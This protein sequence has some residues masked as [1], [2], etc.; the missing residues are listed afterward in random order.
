MSFAQ[1]PIIAVNVTAKDEGSGKKLDGAI[2]K[3]Y[4]GGQLIT[5]K[6]AAS[7]GKVPQIDLEIGKVYQ[8]HITKPGYVTKVAQIDGHFDYPEDLPPYVPFG[9]EVSLFEKMDGV[10]F[11]WLESTPMIKYELSSD[12][13][14]DYDPAYTKQ[15]LKKIEDLKAEMEKKKD[16]EANKKKQFDAFVAAG[17]KGNSAQDYATAVDN[18]DKALALINDP[19]VKA[20]RD[21]AQKAWDEQKK[22]GETEKAFQEKMAQ[23]KDQLL[24]KNYEEALKLYKEASGIK[25]TE[26]LPKDKIKEIED[27]LA[28]QKQQDEQFKKFV[29]DGDNAMGT[30]DFD[31][32]I[33]NYESAL[34]IKEDAAVKTK[35]EDAKKKK[36]EKEAADQAEKD[37]QAKY[38]GLIA[39]ADKLFDSKKYEE[40]KAKYKAALDLK[41]NESHPSA[42]I[43]EIDEILTKMQADADAAKKLEEDYKK[44]IADGDAAFNSKNWQEAIKKY[45][46]ALK[47]KPTENYP[48]DRIKEAKANMDKDAADKEKNEKY[49]NLM[50]EAKGLA[51]AKKYQEAIAKYKEASTVKPDEKDP[52]DRIAELEKIIQDLANAQEKEEKYKSLMADGESAQSKEDYKGALAKYQEALTVKPNDEAA[53]KKI[54]EVNKLIADKDAAQQQEAKFKEYV[55]AGDKDFG[56][57][58]YESA[59]TNYQKALDIKDDQGVK[60]KIKEIDEILKKQADEADLKSK[61]DAAIKA[62][63]DAYNGQKWENALA[64]YEEASSLMPNES[65]PKERIAKIKEKMASDAEQAEKD[66]QFKELVAGGEELA[67]KKDYTGAIKKYQE[68]IKIKPDVEISK[69]I[70][71]L[72]EKKK[73]EESQ[74]ALI[75]Q[76]KKKIEE[77]DNAFNSNSWENAKKLYKEAIDIK[78]DEQYPKDRLTEIDKKMKEASDAEVDAQYQEMIKKADEL[79]DAEKFDEAIAAYEKAKKIKTSESY[80]QQQIDKINEIKAQ[81]EKDQMQAEEFEKKYNDLIAQ[82][83]KAYNDKDY[84]GALKRYKEAIAMK[85]NEAHP[86]G[87]IKEIEDIIAKQNADADVKAKYDAAIA[88]ADNL[89]KSGSYLEA[90]TAYQDALD[91]KGSEQ[92]PKDQIALCDKKMQEQSQNEE[93]EQYQKILTTAQKAFDEK[94]YEKALELYNRALTIRPDDSIPKNKIAEINKLLADQSAQKELQAKYDAAIAKADKLFK[95][96]SYLEAKTAYQDALDIKGNEQYPKDQIALCDKKMQEQSG[97]EEEEQYQKILSTAQ[98]Y[99]DEKNYEKA[100]EL[101]NRALTIR[102]DD[103]VPK[104]KIDEINKILA[105]M[106]A[107]KELQAKFDAAI[108]KADKLFKDGSYLEAKTAYQDALDIKGG[109]Q[110]PKDQIALCDKKMQ[111]QSSNEEEAQYQKILTTAQ[112]YFDEKNYDKALELYNRALSIRPDDSVPKNKIAEINKLLADQ[113]AQK[114][115]KAKY[116]AAIAKADKLFASNNFKDAKTAYQDALDIISS[117]Q[118]PKDQ[119]ALCDQKMQEQSG[120]EEEAQYQKILATA[121]KYFDEKNY[122][123]ALDLYKRAKTIRPSDPLPQQRID[124]INQILNDLNAER[125]KRKRFDDLIQEADT[126]FERKQWKKAL[127]KYLEALD[128]Y[129][130]AYP[131]DQVEKCREGLKNNGDTA[132]KEY[133]KLI[134]KADEYFNAQNY[135]KAKDLYKRAVKLKPSDQYP[136]DQLAEID[137]ILNKPVKMIADSKD[138][139]DYGP[140]TNQRSIDIEAMM[141]EA[142]EQHRYFGYQKIYDKEEEVEEAEKEFAEGGKEE[143]FK[144]K[145]HVEGMEVDIA[146]AQESADDGREETVDDNEELQ[147]NLADTDRDRVTYHENDIQ[148]QNTK[149]DAI[150]TEILEMQFDNDKPRE[151]FELDAEKIKIEV[152]DEN[153]NNSLDQ[154]DVIQD[155][156]ININKMVEEFEVNEGN[157]DLARKNTEVEVEDFNVRIINKNNEDIWDQEDEVMDTKQDVEYINDDLAANSLDDDIPRTEFEE[158]V[159]EIK[160]SHSER[161]NEDADDQEDYNQNTKANSEIMMEEVG[162]RFQD[163]DDDRTEF[164][165]EVVEI[166]QS[167]SDRILEDTD[168][169]EDYNQNTKANSEVMMEEVSER[170]QDIDDDRT[171]FEQEVVEIKESHSER[172]NEDADNQ[173]DYNQN[174][175]ANSEVMMEEVSERFQDIDDDRTEF[176]K[177]VVEIKESHSERENQDADDQ[178]DYNQNTKANSE[179]M[180]EEVS[181]RF[182]DIDDDRTEFE[183]E[184]VEI[185]ESHSERIGQDT[186]DQDNASQKTKSTVEDLTTDISEHFDEMDEEREGYEEVLEEVSSTISDY[187]GDLA[188][189]NE[190]NGLDTKDYTEEM[191]EVQWT[192]DKERDDKAVKQ[193]DNTADA[194]ENHIEHVH[195]NEQANEVDLEANMDYVD[196]LKEIKLNEINPE[197]ENELGQ[198]FPEGVTEESYAV[199]DSNGLLKSYVIRR[200]VVRD[201][202]GKVYEKIQTRYGSVSYTRNGEPISEFQWDD[203]TSTS[204]LT[205]N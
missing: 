192:N 120:S 191:T 121:Q 181:E 124:E 66:K 33:T 41:P 23:A 152:A 188:D 59:K 196:E 178:E 39:E 166:K 165:K 51:D 20:K 141:Q 98:K 203:E 62:A 73:N 183:K 155:E 35:L 186:D 34:G 52:K 164:E 11:A 37:K 72:E 144:T 204:N 63:D 31:K 95:D 5:T 117:E 187:N 102:P 67:N 125:E 96:G 83:D 93:E 97:N 113:A 112:K 159:V 137:R 82:A 175:K 139:K 29:A 19:D 103:S 1:D 89:F 88:K 109:E 17:D 129:Q 56:A 55:A 132:D 116:D 126:F 74:Q 44:F 43:S 2:I 173:E 157:S 50:T 193:A 106:A 68:A 185:K 160:E 42:R 16:E 4:S 119:I 61:Y 180:M 12:G 145:E 110:Y 133:Q 15:M 13:M 154:N 60:D 100:L 123:K 54:D 122:D 135:E 18:Y 71:D 167:H 25:P 158:E 58:S 28:K 107:Q 114:E 150:N 81:R 49:N 57:K 148:Y 140:Q 190:D 85:P 195:D 22:A 171:E 168:N 169:Q 138:L 14:P 172:E 53:K 128:L 48:T 136:K 101:Y 127:D 194:V 202:V 77:A 147:V 146:N 111:E 21:A 94:N 79:R 197:M 26:Q 6:T 118:Y 46:E 108:A 40:A 24:A 115:L 99:F 134:K 176:E 80:P 201:G 78:G 92:Y 30:K 189:A 163:I 27:I 10:D 130:E 179:V 87:R 184:V 104:N 205:K 91:I 142:E 69:R 177:E 32:A 143:T 45:E 8:I 153:V 162:E 199:N 7:N 200:V 64:K 65:Y 70:L 86:K 84:E 76:Y 47:L 149:V 156:R 90:K 131:K 75:E 105:D 170:F 182:Q 174:T 38:D 3:V 161:E 151:Q 9:M 198:K 36:A